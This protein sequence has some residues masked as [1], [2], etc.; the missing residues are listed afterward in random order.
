MLGSAPHHLGRPAVHSVN[1]RAEKPRSV[2]DRHV[3]SGD[4][5]PVCG[6]GVAA[7]ASLAVPHLKRA[8]APELDV[9]ATRQRIL[10]SVEEASTTSPQSFEVAE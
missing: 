10:H 8:E 5:D 3:A 4:L 7:R 1:P 6:P 2:E 9:V